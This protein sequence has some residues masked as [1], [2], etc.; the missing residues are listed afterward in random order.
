MM[1]KNKK[2]LPRGTSMTKVTPREA[3]N[4]IIRSTKEDMVLARAHLIKELVGTTKRTNRTSTRI[5]IIKEVD[6]SMVEVRAATT[7][8]SQIQ[9]MLINQIEDSNML[10][11]VM[12]PRRRKV[13]LEQKV[14]KMTTKAV[15]SIK[16]QIWFG[17]SLI[18]GRS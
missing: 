7:S 3:R 14:G 13:E 1:M 16:F 11:R 5:H 6:S 10:R 15:T 12:D 18:L 9:D 17:T 4:N 2:K 8:N